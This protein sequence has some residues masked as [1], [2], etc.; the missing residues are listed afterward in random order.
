MGGTTGKE[1]SKRCKYLGVLLPFIHDGY[2]GAKAR[3]EPCTLTVPIIKHF[4]M[5]E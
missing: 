5:K 2:I 4:C 1:V 3:D